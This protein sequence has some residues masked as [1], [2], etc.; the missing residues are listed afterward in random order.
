ME[1]AIGG[2]ALGAVYALVALGVI[3]IFR[4]TS[5]VNF[6]QGEI[7]MIG[8][9][10]YTL[11]AERTDLAVVQLAVALAAGSAAGLVCFGVTHFLLKGAGAIVLVIGTL[12]LLVFAQ[13]TA[14]LIFTDNPRR[15]DAWL[16]GDRD[17]QILGATVAANSLT[18]LAL[19]ALAAV[20]LLVWLG[21][22]TYGRSV[23]AVAEDQWRAALSGIHVR[24]MLAISWIIGGALAALGGVLLSP[25]TGVFPT[26]GAQIIFPAF[27]AALLGGFTRLDGALVG[28]LAIGLIQTYAV[29]YFGGV[30][31]DVVMFSLLLLILLVR[32]QGLFGGARVRTV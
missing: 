17:V 32:P 13:S 24:R 9:Y 29:F 12:A 28:G 2:L 6:A 27:I 14:R 30:F 1:L 5:V 16:V 19:T 20:A 26:M 23:R 15:A 8:A 22:T 25:V 7:L 4:A 31:R 3:L 10:A 18:V 11:T 21:A